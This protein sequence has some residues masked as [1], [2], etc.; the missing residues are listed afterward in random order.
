MEAFDDADGKRESG[1][2]F[3]R[4]VEVLRGTMVGT[5]YEAKPRK[6]IGMSGALEYLPAVAGTEGYPT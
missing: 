2:V 1:S 5:L 4:W 6:A 3:L